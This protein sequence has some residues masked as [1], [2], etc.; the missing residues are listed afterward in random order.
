MLKQRKDSITQYEAA[1]RQ[2]L[3]DAEKFEAGV[4]AGLHAAGRCQAAEVEAI[5]AKAAIAES[6]AKGTGG[7]GQGDRA[8]QAQSRRPRRHGRSLGGWSRPNSREHNRLIVFPLRIQ[9]WM[10]GGNEEATRQCNR[11]GAEPTRRPTP[12]TH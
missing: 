9:G 4:L 5:V 7:H 11:H 6:G 1:K 2:D 12:Q 10:Q 3:A 8:G